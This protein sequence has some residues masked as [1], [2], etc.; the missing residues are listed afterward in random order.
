VALLQGLQVSG[1]DCHVLAPDDGISPPSMPAGPPIELVAVRRSPRRSGWSRLVDPAGALIGG[2]FARRLGELAARA[3]VVHLVDLRTAS[4]L[5]VLDRP[6]VLQLDCLTARDRKIRL[7]TGEDREA[8]E[9]L[10]AE[11]RA[12]R[13]ADWMLVNSREV[14]DQLPARIPRSHRGI[15]PLAL[16]RAHYPLRASLEQPIAGMIGTARWPP[17]TRAVERLL[18]RVWP[19]VLE[20]RPNARLLLAGVGM[21]A[22]TFGAGADLPGVEWR[23]HVPSAGDFL[24]ELGVLLYPLTAGSGTKVKVL[25]AM[26]L[27]IPVVTTREGAEGLLDR[28]GLVVDEQDEGI[29]VAT[30]TLLDDLDA[31]RAAGAGAHE[32]FLSHHTPGVA[33]AP[34]VELYERMLAERRARQPGG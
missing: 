12:L 28:S 3:D 32:N 5:R 18:T 2:G 29:A 24:R 22:A 14:A 26:A 33:A 19:L 25:E 13:R 17:T 34:V 8:L 4:A 15:A 10:L 11:R 6:A 27:G 23:G 30:V 16:D 7:R 31:R 20:R 21:E 1:L 9:T